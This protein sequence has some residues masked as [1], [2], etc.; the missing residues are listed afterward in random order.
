[1]ATSNSLITDVEEVQER[2][3]VE[4]ATLQT[5]A[6][7]L[8]KW[9][10]GE[11]EIVNDDQQRNAEDLLI[12]LRQAYKAA[13]EKR[14]DLLKPVDETRSRIQALFKPYLE[15][16]EAASQALTRQLGAYHEAQRRSAEEAKNLLLQQEA[17]RVADARANGEIVE[18]LTF[19]PDEMPEVAKTSHA[20]LG[21]VTYREDIEVTIVNLRLIPRDLMLPDMP[22]IKARAKSGM[23]IPGVLVTKK[24]IPV[25]R[26]GV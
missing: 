5:G 23:E 17:D 1:M 6:S 13:D 15:R 10:E 25:T 11:L 12:G 3:R 22:K 2:V 7:G 20:H 8:L 26:A 21:S 9:S 19:M 14:K 18:A 16:I 24:L 4:I